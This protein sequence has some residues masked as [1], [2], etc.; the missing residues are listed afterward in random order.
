MTIV[1]PAI[2]FDCRYLKINCDIDNNKSK[3]VCSSNIFNLSNFSGTRSRSRSR[4]L[5]II[6]FSV[7]R[8]VSIRPC[9]GLSRKVHRSCLLLYKRL[10]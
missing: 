5:V 7:T 4:Y 2:P 8:L 1:Q 3:D 6:T 10:L 9:F